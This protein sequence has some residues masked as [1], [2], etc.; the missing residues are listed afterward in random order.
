M[1]KVRLLDIGSERI[2]SPARER[3]EQENAPFRNLFQVSR[4]KI[5]RAGGLRLTRSSGPTFPFPVEAVCLDEMQPVVTPM[6]R[7]RFPA[8]LRVLAAALALL[9]LAGCTTTS[10]P[11]L[12]T[13]KAGWNG[14]VMTGPL[15]QFY[16]AVPACGAGSIVSFMS[17]PQLIGI[18]VDEVLLQRL[19]ADRQAMREFAQQ[20]IKVDV[21]GETEV[22][23]IGDQIIITTVKRHRG[24]KGDIEYRYSGYVSGEMTGLSLI[25]SSPNR[26][27]AQ[28]NYE[29][30]LTTLV[31]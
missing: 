6:Q 12:L 28:Q 8:F 7:L 20:R 5:S 15:T 3:S 11:P 22:R 9:A 19:L 29:A 25:S 31:K 24:A 17:A 1:Q 14:P 18:G 4:R 2:P 27:S 23:M 13:E 21:I 30:F 26:K 16:C 10:G